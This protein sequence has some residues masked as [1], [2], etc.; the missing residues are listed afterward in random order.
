MSDIFENF[1]NSVFK[2]LIEMSR[3]PYYLL[4]PARGFRLVYANPAAVEHWGYPRERLMEMAPPDWDPHWTLEDLEALWRTFDPN[5][6]TKL[7]THHRR[8]SGELIPVE[9]TLN[10]LVIGGE[11]LVGG[12]FFDVS[13]R[14][15]VLQG[16][17]ERERRF[18]TLAEVSPNGVFQADAEGRNIYS[19]SGWETISGLSAEET[20]GTGWDRAFHPEDRERLARSWQAAIAA[21][22][23]W[24]DEA[25]VVRPSGEVRRCMLCAAPEKNEQGTVLS[26]V[27]TVVDITE[28]HHALAAARDAEALMSGRERE[29]RI[30]LESTRA[31]PWRLEVA[32]QRFVFIGAQI[33][34][35]LGYSVE[36]WRTMQDWSARIHPEDRAW[37]TAYCAEETAA[38]RNHEF[39]YRALGVDGGVVWIRDVVALLKDEDGRPTDLIG[40]FL[41]VTGEKA[42][43]AALKASE[44][45]Y[46][47][48]IESSGDGFW[49]ADAQGFLLET[50]APYSRLSGYSE[51]ELKGLHISQLE[52]A[53]SPEQTRAHIERLLRSGSE[54]FETRHRSKSG[55]ILDVEVAVSYSPVNGG[56]FFCFVRDIADRKHTEKEPHLVAQV[57]RN[58]SEGIVITQP[59]GII[60]D[61]NEAYCHI[62]GYSREEMIG[63]R[64]NKVSSGRH[65][66]AFFDQMWRSLAE[67]GYWVGE[68][69][70]RRK[71]GEVFPK[72]LTINAVHGP[73]GEL[74]HYVGT[75]SDISALKLVEEQLQHLAYYDALT[76]LPNRTLFQDRLV[77]EINISRRDRRRIAVLFMDLDRFKVVNDTLGHSAGDELLIHV[78]QRLKH[79]LRENDTV[80]RLGGDEFTLIA[81]DVTSIDTVASLA[82]RIITD[83]GRPF[84][85]QGNEV[86]VGASIGISVFPDD[87]KDF[88]TLTMHADAAMYDAK[89]AGRGQYRFYAGAMDHRAHQRLSLE[90]EL[91]RALEKDQFQIY[92]QPQVQAV[93]GRLVGAEALIR[94]VHPERG[95]V[96]PDEFISLAEETGLILPIGEWVL[97]SVC[98]LASGWAARGLKAPPVAINISA[99]QFH[100]Q[101]LVQRID[102]AVAAAGISRESLE[103]E[104]TE[105]VAMTE[106]ER[107]EA[108][109]QALYEAGFSVAIDDFGTGYSSLSYLKRFPVSKLKI[110]RSFIQDTPDDPNDSAIVHA[111]IQMAHTLGIQVV[112]E[113]VE[114]ERQRQFL[115]GR[116]CDYIQGYLIGRPA[117]VAEF[118]K[119]FEPGKKT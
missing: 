4:S 105:S 87:G 116:G 58:T 52:A 93:G 102:Q 39:E 103:L 56:R 24:K 22:T 12:F 42:T 67:D 33:E 70:D 115:E 14:E 95:M 96:A 9:V 84:S 104:I 15:G 110:D 89:N 36:T 82:N 119:W 75:F 46:R 57:F 19:N 69:W 114:T 32:S 38:G 6:Q 16:L 59:D 86:L 111:M 26:H 3:D 78:S 2:T 51:A 101:D 50:N 109:L 60:V 88:D 49:L 45:Q 74:T 62:M 112:A 37:A 71:N 91:Y 94:W 55:R 7:R 23:A 77:H 106:A 40:Y 30:L 25:R 73:D 13:D 27:G 118:E 100:Q 68:V 64:P 76:E 117:P 43:E 81:R 28:L 20:L 80:A 65:D 85:V 92:L 61:V 41:D 63:A 108:Q 99:R 47:A 1:P 29:L 18:R 10:R 54:I 97:N 53:E 11:A 44:A 8:A 66:R 72:W 35:L 17:Q 48:V 21:G 107:A 34:S 98:A 90:S 5:A 113:G 31:V 83:L 79:M